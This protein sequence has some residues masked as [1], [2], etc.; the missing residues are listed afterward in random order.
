MKREKLFEDG[1]KRA[2]TFHY[3]PL[4]SPLLEVG[5]SIAQIDKFRK[6][7]EEINS[8]NIIYDSDIDE[9]SAKACHKKI[10]GKGP[11]ITFAVNGDKMIGGIAAGLQGE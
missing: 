6:S 2:E 11:T 1:F 4:L 10:D 5:L 7:F 3:H 9:K 8:A